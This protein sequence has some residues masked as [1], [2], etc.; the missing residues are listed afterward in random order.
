MIL[1]R[2][3]RAFRLVMDPRLKYVYAWAEDPPPVTRPGFV[4]LIGEQPKPWSAQLICPCG[5]GDVITLS[6]I[7]NDNPRWRHAI[8][9]LGSISLWPSV[10]R[11][12]GCRSH[13]Y[14]KKGKVLWAYPQDS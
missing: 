4:Y 7:E 6:L 1:G 11:T 10:W 13:F 8:H 2:L 3:A 5:C 9:P 14:I 12:K